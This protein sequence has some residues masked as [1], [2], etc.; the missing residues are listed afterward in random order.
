VGGG[1][2]EYIEPDEG[3]GGGTPPLGRAVKFFEILILAP[4]FMLL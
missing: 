2:L 3:G 4:N 1:Q